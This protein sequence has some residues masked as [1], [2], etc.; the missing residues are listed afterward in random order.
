MVALLCEPQTHDKAVATIMGNPND[1]DKEDWPPRDRDM[2]AVLWVALGLVAFT[3]V[4]LYFV[5]S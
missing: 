1:D 5:V 2:D 3:F 4:T